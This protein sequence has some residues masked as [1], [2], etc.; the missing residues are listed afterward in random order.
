MHYFIVDPYAGLGAGYST[1]LRVQKYLIRRHVPYEAYMAEN[2]EQACECA[3]EITARFEKEQRTAAFGEKT[4]VEDVIVVVGGDGT[5][6]DV[7]N[8]LNI[9]A[10]FLFT[11]IPC[12]PVN[13][14]ARGM[15]LNLRYKNALRSIL[16]PRMNTYVD[17]GTVSARLGS[18]SSDSAV[19]R[20]FAVSCGIGYDAVIAETASGAQGR[21]AA[22]RLRLG[23]P[24]FLASAVRELV[25]F[26]T[27][28]GYI[29]L[30]GSKQIS[31][32]HVAFISCQIHRSENGGFKVAPDADFSDGLFDVCVMARTSKIS[33]LPALAS[34]RAGNHKNMRGVHHYRCHEIKIHFDRPLPVHTDS[35]IVGNFT[36]LE[37]TC[38]QRQL[39]VI[40]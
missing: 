28:P 39:R 8:G 9:H 6:N 16:K 22:A 36:D 14:F 19:H 29:V 2:A 17:Y 10:R 37:L 15:N 5:L 38:N 3:K 26:R 24:G 35:E 1:W 32:R 23:A 21:Q 12:G 31:F 20:R 7:L 40:M 33:M 27:V 13:D 18:G 34:I 30:D 25:R 11:C 4:P